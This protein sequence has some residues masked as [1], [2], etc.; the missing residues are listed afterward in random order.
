V[1]RAKLN[2]TSDLWQ[3]RHVV[4]PTCAGPTP[5]GRDH[6]GSDIGLQLYLPDKVSKW[7]EKDYSVH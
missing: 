7:R 4:V 5:D 2:H 3:R 1:A 6:D